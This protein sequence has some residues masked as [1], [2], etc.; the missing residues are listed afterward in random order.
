[1]RRTW[2]AASIAAWLLTAGLLT[3]APPTKPGTNPR[4]KADVQTIC[5]IAWE[6]KL[7]AAFKKAAGDQ[8]TPDRPVMVL[9]VLG[10]LNGFM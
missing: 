9:R 5:D 2:L 6:K 8:N 3:A 4:P 1:M 10:D 7:D